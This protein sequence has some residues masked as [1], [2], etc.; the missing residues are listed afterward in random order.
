MP[1]P[2]EVESKGSI[3]RSPSHLNIV[4]GRNGAGKSRFLRA[5]SGLK[6][7]EGYFVRYVSPERAGTF[8][9][10]PGIENN[11]RLQRDWVESQRGKNQA[12]NFKRASANKLRDLALRFAA[13]LEV[14]RELRGDFSKTFV[15]TQLAKLNSLLTNLVIEREEGQNFVF[16]THSGERVPV[17]DISSGE[18]EA[19]ALA[20]EILH[21]FEQCDDSRTN[22]LLVDEPDVHLHPDLQARFARFLLQELD[23]LNKQVKARTLLVVTTHSTP[24]ICELSRSSYCSIGTKE[25]NEGV[26]V[27]EPASNQ[28]KKM[29][30]F[31]GHPLSQAISSD[32]PLLIEG[33]DD[34][35]I[36]QQAARSAQG[37]LK[38]FPCLA[39]SVNQQTELEAFVDSFLR[40]IYDQPAAISLRDGDGVREILPPIGVVNRFRLQ[41]YAAE[42]LLAT[43]EVLRSLD[44]TWATL[45]SAGLEWCQNNEEH[46]DVAEFEAFLNCPNRGRDRKIKNIRQL[47]PAVLG[48]KKP[49]EVVVGQALGNLDGSISAQ[50][51]RGIVEYVGRDA[52]VAIGLI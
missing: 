35:R 17:H 18:S 50:A 19:V 8:D 28:L 1:L 3:L 25:F 48:S 30:P 29:A 22:I 31:F 42:N 16:K 5:L 11:E 47:I 24:L 14:D 12:D 27:Q 52:L 7:Q 46:K 40:A 51:G 15:T 13:K 21:F 4:V 34:E 10:D 41:C 44:A 33:E 26:V 36:W 32:M 20:T 37:R 39:T 38:I 9:Y 23:E 2:S 45:V 43:D 49:W 6:D